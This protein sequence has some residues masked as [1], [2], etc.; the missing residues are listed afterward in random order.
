MKK[1]KR[2]RPSM[3]IRWLKRC[4]E[5]WMDRYYEG[6]ESPPR[7]YEELRLW[8]ALNPD[9][10]REVIL[11]YTSVLLDAAYRDGFVRGYEWQERGWQG[12]S[13]DPEVLAELQSHAWSLAESNP[14]V[15][16]ILELGYDPNDPLANVAA[17]DRRAFFD[18][19]A[20]NQDIRVLPEPVRFEEP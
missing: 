16:R 9:A 14:R 15:R 11:G 19:L 5:K 17:P 1:A 12:P 3:L 8:A 10:T 6:P 13:I 18:M 7:L 4:F 20:R 2:R